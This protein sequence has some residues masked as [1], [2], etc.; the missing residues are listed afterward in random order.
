[1]EIADY[2]NRIRQPFNVNQIAQSAAIAALADEDFLQE[3]IVSNKQ[4]LLQLSN[5][6]EALGHQFYPR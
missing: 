1:L 2:L 4:G 6:F 5:E 3:S